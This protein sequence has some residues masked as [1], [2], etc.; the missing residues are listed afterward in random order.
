LNQINSNKENNIF[1]AS[2]LDTTKFSQKEYFLKYLQ[3]MNLDMLDLVLSDEATYFG[4]PK[5]VFMEKLSYIKN[6]HELSGYKKGFEIRQYK[7]RKNYYALITPFD[8]APNKFFIE[9]RE[10][11]ISKIYNNVKVTNKEELETLPHFEFFFG[12]DEKVDFRPTTD[13]IMTLHNCTIAYEEL[14]N[15][16]T[17]IITKEFL[18]NWIHEHAL[19]Y[20]EVDKNYLFFK[21]NNF[22]NLYSGLKFIYDHLKY[23]KEANEALKAFPGSCSQKSKLFEWISKYDQLYFCKLL[24]VD[25]DFK[26]ID[27]ANKTLIHIFYKNFLFKGDDFLAIYLFGIIFQYQSTDSGYYQCKTYHPRHKS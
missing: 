27:L 14:M 2:N 6:Q 23:S 8:T 3:E 19:L 13:Y 21:Y 17:Q 7:N 26:N 20:E 9:E 12:N 25:Q 1:L 16:K 11:K 15:N 5:S 10:K 4:A 24:G 18:T 22:R